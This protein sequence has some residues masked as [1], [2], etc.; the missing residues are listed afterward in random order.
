LVVAIAGHFTSSGAP[1]IDLI[2]EGN[3]GLIRAVERFDWRRGIHFGTCASWWIR[4]AVS[5]A[6]SE[7]SHLIHLPERV[8]T[9]LRKVHRVAAQLAQENGT[10]PRAEQIAGAAGLPL[11]DVNALL[12]LPQPPISLDIPVDEDGHLMLVDTVEDRGGE[13]SS[14]RAVQHSL[15]EELRSALSQLT[16]RE[17]AVIVQRYGLDDGH[18]RTLAE[19]GRLLEISRERIR[20]VERV[21]LAK[22]RRAMTAAR[23][24][25]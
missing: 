13:A 15:V 14:A 1:L 16:A 11:E 9:R 22:L 20:R 19:A 6:A 12:R 8:A 10:E 4:Q 23:R 24:A 17:R 2:Q 25:A 5:R 7:H 21:A 3:L 18:S